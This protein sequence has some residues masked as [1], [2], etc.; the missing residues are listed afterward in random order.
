MTD[1]AR[2]ARLAELARR[3]WPGEVADNIPAVQQ[4]PG[5][6]V[7][8]YGRRVSVLMSVRSSSRALDA[9]EAALLVLADEERV[10]L[11]ERRVLEDRIAALERDRATLVRRYQDLERE[12][13]AWVEKLAKEWEGRSYV[14][15]GGDTMLARC[16]RELRERAK[17]ETLRVTDEMIERAADAMVMI[18]KQASWVDLARRALEAA[19][20]DVP[21]RSFSADAQ[22]ALR[23][24][25][26][27]L[28]K[29]REELDQNEPM[30]DPDWRRTLRAILDEAP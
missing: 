18:N 21:E 15:G 25:E 7:E 10:P 4:K 13:A 23:A 2:I 22:R 12:Q 24:A 26:A 14:I 19:L 11:T 8:V 16:A 3:V 28:A 5:H 9:L 20:A 6:W 17:G 29:V 27:K 1:E 30:N